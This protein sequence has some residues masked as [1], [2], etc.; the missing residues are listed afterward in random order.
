MKRII[1]AGLLAVAAG[2][3]MGSI[4]Q[5]FPP[6]IGDSDKHIGRIRGYWMQPTTGRLYDYSAYF[7]TVYPQ[8]PGAMEFTYQNPGGVYP[9]AGAGYPGADQMAGVQGMPGNPGM[10]PTNGGMFGFR[11]HFSSNQYAPYSNVQSQGNLPHGKTQSAVV[12]GN[13]YTTEPP[14][15]IV[16]NSNSQRPVTTPVR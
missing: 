12:G 5:A 7:A 11:R 3:V 8:L 2:C 16:P 10:G 15:A 14:L 4:A 1:L 6:G 9:I 13:V